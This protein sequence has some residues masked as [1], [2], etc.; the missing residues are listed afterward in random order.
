MYSS[1]SEDDDILM[2]LA[3]LY[4]ST[5]PVKK[6]RKRTVW[7][8]GWIVCRYTHSAYNSLILELRNNDPKMFRN[9]L[10][11]DEG[12]FRTADVFFKLFKTATRLSSAAYN[13]F[14]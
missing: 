11:M 6:K 7:V 12:S 13:V 9:F 5:K 4:E 8:K 10:S 1:S 2:S 3:C 14:L